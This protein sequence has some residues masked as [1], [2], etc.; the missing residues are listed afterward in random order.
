MHTSHAGFCSRFILC[1][2]FF[3]VVVFCLLFFIYVRK[4]LIQLDSSD[5]QAIY[6]YFAHPFIKEL[7]TVLSESITFKLLF[8][9]N[10]HVS[11]INE[12]SLINSKWISTFLFLLGVFAIFFWFYS[13]AEA[14]GLQSMY[15]IPLLKDI[16]LERF[17]KE[18]SKT[19]YVQWNAVKAVFSKWRKRGTTVTLPWTEHPPKIDERQKKN[20]SGRLPGDV[21][22]D[23]STFSKNIKK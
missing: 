6:I 1:L 15:E 18:N 2:L 19:L 13:M 14:T 12:V 21:W 4:N 8:K 10:Y 11:F 17:T 16:D 22:L 20:F 7:V 9:S 3:V 23:G 5:L